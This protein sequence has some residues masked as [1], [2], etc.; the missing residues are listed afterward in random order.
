MSMQRVKELDAKRGGTLIW[1][2]TIRKQAEERHSFIE[3]V[4]MASSKKGL[5]DEGVE[6]SELFSKEA[7]FKKV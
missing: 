7:L 6:V 5:F 4:K 3:R 2:Y 1:D